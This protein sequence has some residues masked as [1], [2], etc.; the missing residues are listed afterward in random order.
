MVIEKVKIGI[1]ETSREEQDGMRRISE[2]YDRMYRCKYLHLPFRS[3]SWPS[4]AAAD[5]DASSF[6]CDTVADAF[7]LLPGPCL[8]IRLN[9]VQTIN[10]KRAFGISVTDFSECAGLVFQVHGVMNIWL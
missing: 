9:I 7:A 5:A 1:D 6:C 8:S 3:V 2:K 4:R 10:T